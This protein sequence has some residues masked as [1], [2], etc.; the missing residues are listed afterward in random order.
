MKYSQ[1]KT[2]L[3]ELTPEQLDQQDVTIFWLDG[4]ITT[5]VFCR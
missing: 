1:L 3:D 4:Q 5:N 2:F